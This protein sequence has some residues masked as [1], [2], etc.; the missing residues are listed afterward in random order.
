MK[1]TNIKNINT[2]GLVGHIICILLMIATITA[3]VTIGIG[4]AGAIAVSKEKVTVKLDTD[5]NINATG[6]ILGKLNKFVGVKGIENLN[7]LS[8][9]GGKSV[10]TDD[11]TVSGISVKTNDDGSMEIEV[12]NKEVTLSIARI[13]VSL[14]VSF[15]LMAAITVCIHFLDSL[16][17]SLRKCQTPFSSDV[18]RKM[19]RFAYSLIP[20]AVIK[21]LCGG[22]WSGIGSS[23]ELSFSTDLGTVMLAAIVFL[24]IAVFKYGAQ[25]QQES[26]ETL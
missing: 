18:I 16:M 11:S 26:D 3:M 9:G 2:I 19:T 14:V 8:E 4:T 21:M 24:L 10:K 12:Q 13:I 6:N 22:F 7:D 20:V 15:L 1:E 17:K 5:I 23:S 25:L